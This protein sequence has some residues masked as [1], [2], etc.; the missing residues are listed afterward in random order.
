MSQ[1][2]DLDA[3][4]AGLL[5]CPPA[6]R[7]AYLN[8]A[9]AD[10][11]VRAQLSTW[12]RECDDP[13][14][15]P[16][17]AFEGVFGDDLADE[18]A[19]EDRLAQ[20]ERVGAYR[21]LGEVGRGGMAVV[22]LAERADGAF[23]QRVALKVVKR[24]LDTDE[25]L[26]RFLQ[27]RQI[28][29][30]LDHP[31]IAR[32][33]DGGVMADGRPFLVME[34]VDG[35]PIDRYADDE[36]L[37]VDA[38]LNLFVQ[39]CDAVSRA[40][41]H[42]VI[43]RD[44]KP[45]N[46]L[47]DGN[48]GVKLVDFGVAKLLLP[49]ISGDGPLTRANVR[50]MTPE[51]A[52][53]E[54]CRGEPIT[55]A[56]DV[57][58]LGVMLYEL[59]A[60]RRPYEE[61]HAVIG[62][63]QRDRFAREPE[64]PSSA[65]RAATAHGT[66]A[67][68]AKARGMTV[69]GLSRRLRGDLDNIVLAALRPEPDRRYESVAAL[70]ADIERHRS[71]LPVAARPATVR[72]RTAKFVR[73]HRV[74]VAAI[75]LLATA[76][77]AGTAATLVQANATAREGRRAEQIRD[78]LV[79]VFE[80]S[81]PN[82]SRG[83]TVTAREL[84]DRGSER[85]ERDLSGDP[86]LRAEMRTV[87]GRLYHRLGLFDEARTHLSDAL[88]LRRA[89]GAMPLTLVESLTNLAGVRGEDGAFDDARTLLDEA[90]AIARDV[91]GET[92]PTVAAVTSDLAAVYRMQGKYAEAEELYRQSL[93]T[94]RAVGDPA[95]LASTLNGLG[96][97]LDLAGR[98]KEAVGTLQEAIEFGREAHG[99][100]HTQVVLSEC[101]LASA[102]HHA[103]QLD[104]ALPAFQRCIDHRRRLLGDRH[105][106][107]AVALNN[108]AL[109]HSDLNAYEQAEP[110]HREALE[111]RRAAFGANH[112]AVAG[113]LNNL[114]ILAFQRSRYADAA[115]RFKELVGLW[116]ALVGP[117]HPDTLTTANNLG[118]ALRSAGDLDGAER[119]LT[120]VLEG[121]TRTLGRDHPEVAS[122]L[123][124]LATVLHRQSR[125]RRARE[126]AE[127]A[128]PILERAYPD[129]HPMIAIGHMTRARALL[130]EGA[131]ADALASFQR[132]FDLREKTFGPTHLQTAE[133]RVGRGRALA[134][135]GRRDEGR[136]E[137]ETA[138]A[139]LASAGRDD[140][141]TAAEAR[142]ALAALDTPHN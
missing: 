82:R 12:L 70:R 74:G 65:C 120:D 119:I 106:D 48:G 108:A 46:V 58:S 109:L 17:G 90:L 54:Q 7:D 96:V 110:L 18:L 28:L 11:V 41:Q 50:V 75:V 67:V 6:D 31:A 111:I 97:V 130:G 44:L 92:G 45:G 131:P 53:P 2:V 98:P 14:V 66:A 107:L 33:L 20:G 129:G 78:F 73:R 68:R 37:S 8:T 76:V 81:D 43:H 100:G 104:Q 72:Y 142:E 83:A 55:T 51:Y 79:G 21:I 114:A 128:L 1:D 105:P 32:L 124:N 86:V 26:S 123:L 99:D 38:R 69:D 30:S 136:S 42:L 139:H 121:R 95:G 19:R 4:L 27:E 87:L 103:G 141:A 10:P 116:H 127:Q 85:V 60:G 63:V 62:A 115:A 47:V 91:E 29:A 22:Y 71:G 113:S 80:I 132:A 88:A 89:N 40:H 84:L 118:M 3:L 25:T 93:I 57:Y 52:S 61:R 134:A 15:T 122:S 117:D 94:R 35:R 56:T 59:L 16:G 36:G 49:E 39:V 112:P 34:Y 133:V 9:R 101:N 77:A 140:S 64:L 102:L 13:F 135:L 23:V 5:A 138:L 137:I 125:F 24:G 126:L